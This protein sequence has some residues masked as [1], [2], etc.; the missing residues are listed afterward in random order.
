M[1]QVPSAGPSPI[2]F[3]IVGARSPVSPW[4][5]NLMTAWNV[6]ATKHAS[7]YFRCSF[8]SNP[9]TTSTI[10]KSAMRLILT[11][12]GDLADATRLRARGKV[13]GRKV[14]RMGKVILLLLI[15]TAISDRAFALSPRPETSILLQ[16]TPFLL[17]D[18][19]ELLTCPCD[20]VTSKNGVERRCMIDRLDMVGKVLERLP[21]PPS[22][23]L[24]AAWAPVF[25]KTHLD[26][27]PRT[28]LSAEFHWTELRRAFP[29]D[30]RRL[31]LTLAG[32]VLTCAEPGLPTERRDLGCTPSEVTVFETNDVAFFDPHRDPQHPVVVVGACHPDA[33]TKHEVVAVCG[34]A[35][36][37]R[38]LQDPHGL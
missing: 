12:E 35:V 38:D 13:D 17:V 3:L 24:A 14:G 31:T 22:V 27:H 10:A 36:S 2:S 37:R 29:V 4:N 11:W 26:G 33:Q 6:T 34:A 8:F 32:S 21:T 30:G 23:E 16:G 28:Q 25:Q 7:Q 1:A 15:V 5:A 19:S 18:K 20:S 9:T